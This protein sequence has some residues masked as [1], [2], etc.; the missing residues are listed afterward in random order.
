MDKGYK[1][2]NR[3]T[4]EQAEVIAESAQEACQKLGWVIGDCFVQELMKIK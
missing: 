4:K 3:E 2:I 1:I